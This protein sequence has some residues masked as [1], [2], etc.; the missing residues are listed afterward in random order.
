M[1]S[2]KYPL[3][4]NIHSS[5]VDPVDKPWPRLADEIKIVP[6]VPIDIRHADTI[7][8][9]VMVDLHPPTLLI[10]DLRLETDPT[11]LAHILKLKV[12]KYTN[13]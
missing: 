5:V 12:A 4:L 13:F 11:L 6:T 10:H 2:G 7:P 9:I 3:T 1:K 8:M